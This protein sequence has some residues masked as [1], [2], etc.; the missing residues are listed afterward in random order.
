MSKPLKGLKLKV[1]IYLQIFHSFGEKRIF[2]SHSDCDATSEIELFL[3][4]FNRFKPLTNV[5]KNSISDGARVLDRPLWVRNNLIVAFKKIQC[6]RNQ[7]LLLLSWFS[8]YHCYYLI[9]LYTT[10][11]FFILT[12]SITDVWTTAIK[13]IK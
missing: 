6:Q 7:P 5:T 10:F 8:I 12:F 2:S 1:R 11:Y 9:I 13:Q 4:L 3:I